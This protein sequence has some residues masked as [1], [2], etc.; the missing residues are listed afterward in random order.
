MFAKLL[1]L[2]SLKKV[3]SLLMKPLSALDRP[4]VAGLLK[5]V[6]VLYAGL[7]APTLPG[8]MRMLL[9]N[10]IMKVLA[11]FLIVYTGIKDPV[12]SLLIAVGFTVSMMTL[13]KLETVDSLGG[14]FDA[15]IDVPQS[16]ANDVVDGTQDLVSMAGDQIAKLPVVGAPL[17]GI[18]S[19]ANGLVN[20]AQK[21]ANVA[22]DTVQ[23]VVT[24]KKELFSM[25]DRVINVDSLPE[26]GILGDLS[27]VDEL[28][29]QQGSM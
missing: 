7:I 8:K 25:E 20:V 23:S 21:Y 22:I 24:G 15:V 12:L 17:K 28:A 16:F 26:I 10:P 13:S 9:K 18:E 29:Q 4:Y 2:L 14:V 3:G 11:M 5:L 27:G 6:L 1:K 19:S